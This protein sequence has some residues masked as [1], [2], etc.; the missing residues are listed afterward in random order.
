MDGQATQKQTMEAMAGGNM[1][2]AIAGAGAVVLTILALLNVLPMILLSIAVIAGGAGMMF[3]GSTIAGEYSNLLS[4][5]DTGELHNLNIQSGLSIEALTGAAGIALGILSLLGLIPA[6]LTAI[7]AIVL[8]C[9]LAISSKSISRLNKLKI[10]HSGA[11]ESARHIA[12]GAV[13]TASTSHVFIGI[14]AVVLGI[15]TI[16]GLSHI[17]TVIG[18][19]AVGAATLLSGMAIGGEALETIH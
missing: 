19:L 1:A 18:V 9:G 13:D 16:V 4:S 2:E 8:G 5:Q 15:L 17:L 11:S 14:G 7:S 6:L 10:M 3:Q 12:H